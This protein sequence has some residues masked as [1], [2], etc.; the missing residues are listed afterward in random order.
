MQ[1]K[2]KDTGRTRRRVAQLGGVF[3]L[4][5]VSLV[6]RADT[7]FSAHHAAVLDEDLRLMQLWHRDGAAAGMPGR[8]RPVAVIRSDRIL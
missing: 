3:A 6:G 1:G 8:L 7:G 5:A 4:M 2:G